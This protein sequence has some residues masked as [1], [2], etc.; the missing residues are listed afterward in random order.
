MKNTHYKIAVF[1]LL[2]LVVGTFTHCVQNSPTGGSSSTGSSRNPSGSTA[3]TPEQVLN[4]AQVEVGMKNFEQINYSFADLT[5]V[6]VS[7]TQV[8]NTYAAVEATLPSENEVKILQSSNQVAITRLA[9]EYCNQLVT[10]G[11]F[12]ASRDAIFTAA[13]FTQL[14]GVVDKQALA[15]RTTNA[16]WGAGIIAQS[17]LDDARL[18]LIA[19]FDDIIAMEAAGTRNSTGTT[20]KA[21]RAVC[22]AA[23]SSAYVTIM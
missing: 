15:N 20:N 12:T 22:T 13:I 18:E 5:G 1:V 10:N 11:T 19:L 6:P 2:N 21:V 8:N 7:N 17:E 16:F 14:P 23:L 9:A 3:Q 4:Q